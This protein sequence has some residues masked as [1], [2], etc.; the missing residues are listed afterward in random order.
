MNK[1]YQVKNILINILILLVFEIIIYLL[2]PYLIN[3]IKLLTGIII[4]ILLIGSYILN[5]KKK[6]TTK[7][8]TNIIIIIGIL[9]RT[10]Y[11]VYTPI[12]ERQHDVDYF[13]YPGHLSYMNI[14]K[15]TGKLPDTNDGQFYHPPL[16]HFIGAT[17]LKVNDVL[18]V[19]IEKNVEGL[20]ILTLI[21]SSLTL[22]VISQ[23]LSRLKIKDKYNHLINLFFCVNPTFIIL[24]GSINNDCL[25]YLFQFI[26][27][28]YI[29][30]YYE[31]STLKNSIILGLTTGLCMLT[32]FNGIIML[33]PI[34]ILYLYKLYKDRNKK[35][36][37]KN[38]SV[39]IIIALV[40]GLSF[41]V[42]NYYL[43]GTIAVPSP[44]DYLSIE[45]YT[46]LERMI[47]PSITSIFDKFCQIPGDYNI[48]AY[49]IKSSIFGEYHY[50]IS[51][52]FY[53]LFII[54]NLYLIVLSTILII[55][56]I[57]N[58]FKDKIL[59]LLVVN[60]FINILSYYYFNYSYPY[61]CTMD[62]RYLVPT[63]LTGIIVLVLESNN[64]K[65]KVLKYLIIIPIILFIILSGI[66]IFII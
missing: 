17:W 32:K 39:M 33:G 13:N 9:L 26:I 30:K 10:M 28:L 58:I 20:Q 1:K 50:N 47:I 8:I 48:F 34:T 27:L 45:N 12:T 23:I 3:N 54:T 2:E 62:F 52:L 64:T 65:N 49:I 11:I 42:R 21:F 43:Y 60:Y 35:E 31:N 38:Y 14:I 55:K 41:Q 24:S 29:L 51:N 44:S 5:K 37:I 18:N 66:F 57:K 40:L 22:F 63:L 7:A 61:V 46:I 56:N 4:G 36:I 25:E 59:L 53:N 16:H 15:E 6:L 19:P